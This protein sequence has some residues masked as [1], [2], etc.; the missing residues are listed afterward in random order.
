MEG[1]SDQLQAEISSKVQKE[2]HRIKSRNFQRQVIAM[3]RLAAFLTHVEVLGS[4]DSPM[5]KSRLAFLD[6]LHHYE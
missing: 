5:I 2:L 4:G 6:R 3:A 1:L